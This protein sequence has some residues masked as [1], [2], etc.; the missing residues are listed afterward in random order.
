MA[1]VFMKWLET[2]RTQFERSN[3]WKGIHGSGVSLREGVRTQQ[4]DKE[5]RESL[6]RTK[7]SKAVGER[8]LFRACMWDT[9]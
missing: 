6:W 1:T 4:P 5:W 8:V 9:A 2:S 3:V 7:D